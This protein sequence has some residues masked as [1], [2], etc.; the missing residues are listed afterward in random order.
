MKPQ[1]VFLATHG[2]LGRWLI[3]RHG[4]FLL[5]LCA[6]FA[7][8]QFS[9][10]TLALDGDEPHVLMASISILKGTFNVYPSYVNHDYLAL[11]FADLQWQVAPISGYIPPEHG[12]MFAA[13][14]AP[15]YAIAGVAGAKTAVLTASVL[16]IFLLYFNCLWVGLRPLGAFI[17]GLLLVSTPPWEFH[18]ALVLPESLA[19]AVTMGIVAAYLR[20][21]Q[22]ERSRWAFAIGLLTLLLPMMYLKY[23]AIAVASGIFLVFNRNL[24]WNW[25]T[26]AAAPLAVLYVALWI[27]V[28]GPSIA[29]GT[30]AGPYEF[31]IGGIE[32]H[33]WSAFIDRDHGILA[34]A[35]GVA[36]AAAGLLF[37]RR[38]NVAVQAF[39]IVAVAAY[40]ALYGAAL[41]A[42][43]QSLPGRYLVAVVPAMALLSGVAL[44]REGTLYWAR[45]GLFATF[46][47]A[48]TAIM[49]LSI[50]RGHPLVFHKYA[51]MF[52]RFYYPN[53]P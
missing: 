11:G 30:G 26:Y 47:V 48:N 22:T 4:V 23:A 2:H 25:A 27:E 42:P 17:A 53:R 28:Y 40:A 1:G 15:F 51:A 12:F 8:C 32:R 46:V 36:L 10:W 24:R 33:I 35:P 38:R 6:A 18:A 41:I 37:W 29:M 19:G 43:G 16:T 31:H 44:L 39:L 7:V 20:F 14:L 3:I 5:C 50:T 49:Y 9:L 52:P 21:T 45:V 13:L 34:W